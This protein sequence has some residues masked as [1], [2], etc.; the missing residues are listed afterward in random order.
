MGWC[1]G[2]S[3]GVGTE[4]LCKVSQSDGSV[5]ALLDCMLAHSCSCS[6]ALLISDWL[7]SIM[8]CILAKLKGAGAVQ[9]G[10]IVCFVFCLE[11][12]ERDWTRMD[13]CIMNIHC[14]D[15][16]WQHCPTIDGCLMV[17]MCDETWR[18]F[19]WYMGCYGMFSTMPN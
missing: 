12:T 19:W 2:S 1:G 9:F 11:F 14:Q 15:M 3:W 7:S 18:I 4:F 5:Q 16:L 17:Q 6:S 13:V 10:V 8:H